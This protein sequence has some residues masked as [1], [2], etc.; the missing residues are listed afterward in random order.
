MVKR[1]EQGMSSDVFALLYAS[2]VNM[3]GRGSDAGGKDALFGVGAR[4]GER[5]ADDFFCMSK[6]K[7]HMNALEVSRNI[8][9]MF[10]P[11]YFSFRPVHAHGMVVLRKFPVLQYTRRAD[12]CLEMICGIL[13]GVYSHIS[14][15]SLGFEA[16]EHNGDYCI[17]VRSKEEMDPVVV[18]LKEVEGSTEEQE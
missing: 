5:L 1:C 8:S 17:L 9:E 7:R 12:G 4:I 13:Q 10:F 6:P 15:D 18:G 3:V 2:T 14:K 11:Y 16:V